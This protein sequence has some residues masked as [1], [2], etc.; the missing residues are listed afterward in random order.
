MQNLNTTYRLQRLGFG[1]SDKI[2]EKT[3]HFQVCAL[4]S[5]LNQFTNAFCQSIFRLL[6]NWSIMIDILKKNWFF[7]SRFNWWSINRK[8]IGITIVKKCVRSENVLQVSKCYSRA[9]QI[10]HFYCQPQRILN[11]NEINCRNETNY[12]FLQI[13]I[14][15]GLPSK[16][17]IFKN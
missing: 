13:S 7:R 16:S 4:T 8:K 11:W 1:K 15:F 12:Y 10:L 14:K 5:F 2:E 9:T 17:Y 6:L 3:L